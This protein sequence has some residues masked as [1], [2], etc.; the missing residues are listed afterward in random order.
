MRGSRGVGGCGD[1]GGAPCIRHCK[2]GGEYA[3]GHAP[4]GRCSHFLFATHEPPEQPRDLLCYYYTSTILQLY[5]DYNSNILILLLDQRTLY[6]PLTNRRS[7]R[8]IGDPLA[9]SCTSSSMPVM[10]TPSHPNWR[11][12]GVRYGGVLG[13]WMGV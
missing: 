3:R 4:W 5:F 7:S 2:G 13:V 12:R 8:A 1:G 9:P 10:V 6:S 11:G